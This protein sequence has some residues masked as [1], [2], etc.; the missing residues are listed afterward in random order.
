MAKKKAAP[1]TD[2][3][4][5]IHDAIEAGKKKGPTGTKG[6]YWYALADGDIRHHCTWT[7]SDGGAEWAYGFASTKA[8]HDHRA[9]MIAEAQS[10]LRVTTRD[11]FGELGLDTKVIP[12]EW[13]VTPDTP[14]WAI[15]LLAWEILQKIRHR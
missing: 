10:G 5:A 11:P 14:P 4:A 3:E 8:A 1:R 2:A 15:R 9:G 7:A 6:V 13:D 12:A